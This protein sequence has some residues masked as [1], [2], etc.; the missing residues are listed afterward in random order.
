MCWDMKELTLKIGNISS[1]YYQGEKKYYTGRE[2]QTNYELKG[3]WTEHIYWQTQNSFVVQTESTLPA[4]G[5]K[6]S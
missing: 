5:V 1:H 3:Q 4:H 6:V 2:Q